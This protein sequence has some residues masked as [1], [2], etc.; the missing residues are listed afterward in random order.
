MLTSVT[1]IS[2]VSVIILGLRQVRVH[3]FSCTNQTNYRHCLL[4]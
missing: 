4:G 3:V 1:L 2:L